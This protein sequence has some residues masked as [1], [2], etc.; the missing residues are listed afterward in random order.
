MGNQNPP[1]KNQNLSNA[2]NYIKNEEAFNKCLITWSELMFE[3]NEL[4]EAD[5]GFLS[6]AYLILKKNRLNK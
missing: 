2:I 5:K 1:M 3:W 6:E 4:T